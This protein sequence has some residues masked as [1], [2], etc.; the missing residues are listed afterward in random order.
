MTIELLI[1]QDENDSWQAWNI[2][3]HNSQKCQSQAQLTSNCSKL[4][5]SHS[6]RNQT[7]QICNSRDRYWM[8]NTKQVRHSKILFLSL[9]W[10]LL[11]LNHSRVTQQTRRMDRTC[12]RKPP[13]LWLSSLSSMEATIAGTVTTQ[14]LLFLFHLSVHRYATRDACGHWLF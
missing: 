9:W 7:F 12:P 13:T 8:L 10:V 2:T 1:M 6:T 4:V 3:N 14:L 11:Y 5:M